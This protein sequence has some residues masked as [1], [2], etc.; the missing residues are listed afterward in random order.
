M[1]KLIMIIG[2]L[3]LLMSQINAAEWELVWS[4]EFDYTGLP[5]PKKWGYEE[6]FVRNNEAQY[7]TKARKENARVEDGMLII[8]GIKEQYKN[9]RFKA[10]SDNWKEKPEFSSY[11]AASLITKHTQSW[12]YGRIEVKAKLPQG[13]GMWPAIWTLGT[14]I[15]EISWPRCGEID[16]MEFVGKEPNRIHANAHFAIDGKHSSG[17]GKTTFEKPFD[18]FHIYAIEWDAENIHFFFDQER[19]YSFPIEKAQQGEDNPF[20]K[21]HYLLINLALGGSW[22]G[23]IDDSVLPQKFL[24]D[25]V[26]IYQVKKADK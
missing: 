24:V 23:P 20:R 22:G 2:V 6:G 13:K 25:Y 19:Y 12:T 21:P 9:P 17:G 16:I 15:K 11:T 3:V 18:A 10:T 5:D 1:N 4:D 14:N 26:R 7:Y 8:E